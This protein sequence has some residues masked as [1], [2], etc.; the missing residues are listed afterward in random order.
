MLALVALTLVVPTLAQAQPEPQP[1]SELALQIARGSLDRA[2]RAIA[3]GPELGAGASLLTAPG[4][5]ELPVSFGL[6]LVLFDVPVFPGPRLV[7]DIIRARIEARGLAGV[8]DPAEVYAAVKAEVLGELAAKARAR[9]FE[10]PRG[11]AH[12]EGVYDVRAAA[13]EARLTALFGIGRLAAGPT[14][15]VRFGGASGVVAGLEADFHVM[16]S[17]STRSMPLI[18]FL[19]A[20]LGATDGADAADAVVLGARVL[21][22]LI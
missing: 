1:S 12:L 16:L 6:G 13:W 10:R 3:F 22:D 2:R 5:L 19:R 17:A 11:G 7:E 21:F 20:E 14:L 15:A 9:R 4:E 8:S 18:V